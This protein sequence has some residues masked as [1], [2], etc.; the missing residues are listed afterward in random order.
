MFNFTI[1]LIFPFFQRGNIVQRFFHGRKNVKY[2]DLYDVINLSIC[3]IQLFRCYYS[4][5]RCYYSI[6]LSVNYHDSVVLCGFNFNTV[7]L[8]LVL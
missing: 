1:F 4:I 3:Y 8:V 7:F 2:T 6:G 5:F